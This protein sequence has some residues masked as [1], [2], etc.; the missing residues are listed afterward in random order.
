MTG[1]AVR[2]QAGFATKETQNQRHSPK[3]QNGASRDARPGQAASFRR[4]GAEGRV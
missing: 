2:K 3:T 1:S 4:T